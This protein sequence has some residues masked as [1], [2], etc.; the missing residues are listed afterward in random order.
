MSEFA[1]PVDSSSILRGGTSLIVELDDA[2]RDGSPEWRAETLRRITDLFLNDADRLSEQ[3]IRVFDDVLLHLIKRIETKALI[4]LSNCLAP[5]DNA[6]AEVIRHLARDDEILVARPVLSQSKRLTEGDLIQIAETKSQAH[7]LA[8]SGRRSL[9]EPLTD[10][11]VRRGDRQ[12][13]YMLAD[14]SGARFSATGFA[15]LAKSGETDE[16]LAQKLSVRLDLPQHLLRELLL[17]ATD[18]VRA[19]L[20]AAAPAEAQGR[21]QS[22]LA[23]IAEKIGREAD[24]PRDFETAAQVVQGLNRSGQLN[25]SAVAGFARAHRHEE[26]VIALSLLCSAPAP[27]I[28]RLMKKL[29]PDGLIVALRAA[30]LSWPAAS[31]ILNNRFNLHSMPDDELELA[32]E[33]YFALSQSSAQRTLRFWKARIAARMAS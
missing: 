18:A 31:T 26:V 2:L 14:N 19:R 27:L 33:A 15:K 25:E 22:A 30:D 12:V 7:L 11:L 20:L 23:S 3:Q 32:K 6:P 29:R 4:E 9:N 8:I 5:M 17:R 21:I 24:E 1:M 13:T 10:V 28:E 16:E